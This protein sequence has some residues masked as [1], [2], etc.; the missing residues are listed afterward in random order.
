MSRPVPDVKSVFSRAAEIASLDERLAFLDDACEGFP[1]VRAEVQE[2]LDAFGEAGSF[3]GAPAAPGETTL[4]PPASREGEGTMIGPYKLMEQIGEGGMGLVFV[5]E[6]HQPVRRKVALKVIKPGMDSRQV[7]ARFEAERQALAM[8][9]HPNI[10]SVFDGGT[11]DGGRPYFV[12]ELVRGVPITEYCDENNLTTRERL[13]LFIQVCQAVQHAHQKGVIHRD[14]KPSNILVAP[15]DGV[16]V[17]KVIDFGVAKALGQ[18]LTEKTVYTRFAQMIGTP[19][20]MSPE[21]AEVNQLDVDTRSDVYSLGVLLYELLTGTTPFDRGRFQRAAFDEIRRIIREEEPPR[22]STRL[23]SL[24]DTLSAVSARRGT[25]PARLSNLL[26]GELDW[27]VMRCLEKDR[28]R[29]YETVAGLSKDVQH[30]LA[31]E[32]VEARPASSWYRFQKSYRR[33]RA[34]VLTAAGFA[35]LLVSGLAGVTWKWRAERAAR[36]EADAARRDAESKAQEL[37]EGAERMNAANAAIDL[38]A[39]E[40]TLNRW[41]A[42]ESSH[43]RAIELR[44]DHAQVWLHRGE[45][46]ATMGLWDLAAEDHA[47]SFDHRTPDLA[48][49]WYEAA[50]LFLIRGDAPAYRRTCERM[51]TRFE[52]SRDPSVLIRLVRAC[53]LANPIPAFAARPIEL[54]SRFVPKDLQWSRLFVRG[55]CLHRLGRDAEAV[56]DLRESLSKTSFHARSL[57][58]PV[59]AMALHRSGQ[60]EAARQELANSRREL[61]RLLQQAIRTQADSRSGL[62]PW[63]YWNDWAEFLYFHDEAHRLIEGTAMPDDPRRSILRGRGL[64]ALKRWDQAAPE[65]ARAVQLAPND[66]VIR[67]E[68]FRFH[69][70][71][72]GLSDAQTELAT[73]KRIRRRDPHVAIEAFRSYADAGWWDRAEEELAEAVRLRPDDFYMRLERFRYHAALGESDQAEAAFAAATRGREAD[74]PFRIKCAD[75][76]SELKYWAKACREYSSILDADLA[77]DGEWNRRTWL[78]LATLQLYTDDVEGYR[79]ACGRLI[80]RHGSVVDGRTLAML[81]RLCLLHADPG[82]PPERIA[83][84]M[85]RMVK[86]NSGAT[87]GLQFIIAPASLRAGREVDLPAL[88]GAYDRVRTGALRIALACVQQSRGNSGASR[89]LLNGVEV[90]NRRPDPAAGPTDA[91]EVVL[92]TQFRYLQAEAVIQSE[93]WG[94]IDQLM[95]QKRWEAAIDAI[96][97]FLTPEDRFGGDWGARAGCFAEL[98]RWDEAAADARKAGALAPDYLPVAIAHGQIFLQVGDENSYLQLCRDAIQR[99]G[100]STDRTTLN[101]AAW[102]CVLAPSA[103]GEAARALGLVEKSL[104][105][106]SDNNSAH[107]RACLLYRL[108]R[109]DEALKQLDGLEGQPGYSATAYD[110]LFLAMIHHRLGGKDRARTYLDRAV[111][112]IDTAAYLGWQQRAELNRFRAEAESLIRASR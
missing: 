111:A 12:M 70:R 17:V 102:L 74:V 7:V 33:H 28:T 53:S 96:T 44:P 39:H 76:L 64:A 5:A 52:G 65:Y 104:G 50:L 47:R 2:L 77:G 15:H 20:Y 31:D 87:Q 10:A 105:K 79:R 57:V 75:A 4:D 100:Q 58:Y 59:L 106:S 29:R 48:R 95:K 71:R 85:D 109:D 84:L 1:G 51:L 72:G 32:A 62:V 49:Q 68:S 86:A 98:G 99:H 45:L 92:E 60:V 18:Q 16:P 34:S 82:V 93:R 24:G 108:G 91:W 42:A 101:N 30:Y 6:Q 43:G 88:Q 81:V 38:A 3:M 13:G 103:A 69:V 14:L 36:A 27:I 78:R 54:D 46:Y 23:T 73:V 40:T 112:W 35:L 11:T 89:N 110:W 55:L 8:M 26:R 37:R 90:G 66:D 94:E 22:P 9:D 19:L 63:Q 107:T 80:E 41:A 67:L 21:Q 56:H 25:D 61:D 83:E 97:P